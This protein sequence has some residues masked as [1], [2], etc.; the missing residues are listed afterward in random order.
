MKLLPISNESP[1]EREILEI[2]Y[3]VGPSTVAEVRTRLADAP[4]YSAVR[5]MLTRLVAK[6][7]LRITKEGARYV[8]SPTKKR[9]TVSKEAL[10]RVLNTYF[11]GSLARAVTAL[12]DDRSGTISADD[13][14]ELERRLGAARRAGR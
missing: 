8:Y 12:L 7:A 5:T 14:R 2:I 1:R 13:A 9:E 3:A 6:G 4:G 10:R 11:E